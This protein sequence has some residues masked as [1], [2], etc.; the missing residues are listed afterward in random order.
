MQVAVVGAGPSGTWASILLAR[1]GHSVALIDPQAP[2]EKPCGGGVTA[3]A[4]SKF[5]IFETDLPRNHIDRMTIYFGDQSSVSIPLQHPVAVVSRR[6]LSRYLFREAEKAGV[7]ILKTRITHF[8]STSGGWRLTARNISLQSEFLIGA[9]GA[10]S[11]VRRTLGKALEAKDLC[12]TL[13]YFIPEIVPA[14]M[15]I[16]FL[17]AFEGYIWSF[18]RPD[19]VSYGIISRSDPGWTSRAKVLLSNFIMADLGSESLARAEFFSAPVPCLGRKAWRKNQIAG[20]RWALVGD[21]AG[22][23]DP[24]SGEGIYFALKSA[25]IL[26][27][28]IER[29]E[30][31]ATKIWL[32]IGQELSRAARMH[33]RFYRGRFLGVDFKKRL[34]QFSKRS[35]TVRTI[36][37]N[38]MSGN[39]SYGSL[40]KK[41][42]FSIPSIGIDMITGRS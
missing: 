26:A 22:L 1:L 11:L 36:V 18:P 2:W 40:K 19:H 6:E 15:K 14:Q 4:L 3:K 23:A 5:D 38:V 9:D 21:A 41:L 32:E 27:E 28:T 17:P 10:T 20:H 29:P 35:R 34:V 39:Q 37:G 12:V 8:E 13:G 24:I 33:K 25:Q 16:Y 42:L 7:S 31:Y 30:E